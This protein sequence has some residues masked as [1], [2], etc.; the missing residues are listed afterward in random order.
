MEKA[1]F[2]P[3][4]KSYSKHSVNNIIQYTT[5]PKQTETIPTEYEEDKTFKDY[6]IIL[7]GPIR[8]EE[9][10]TVNSV[11]YYRKCY[12]EASIIVST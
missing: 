10:F 9:Q 8:S 5:F 1:I 4:I 2:R 12:P 3:I 7:Q 6:A 11:K